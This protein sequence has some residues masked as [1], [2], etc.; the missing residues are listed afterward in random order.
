MTVT[1]LN[2]MRGV[3]ASIDVDA[4]I[5]FWRRAYRDHPALSPRRDFADYE[6]AIRI[7]IEAFIEDPDRTFEDCRDTLEDAYGARAGDFRLHWYDAGSAAAAAWHR[8]V[9]LHRVRS[10]PVNDLAPATHDPAGTA[11]AS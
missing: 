4:E 7:G 6:L 8:L 3:P 2:L 5:D 1:D 10:A 9:R 11:L